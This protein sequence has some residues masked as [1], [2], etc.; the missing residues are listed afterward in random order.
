VSPAD[1]DVIRPAKELK[2][3]E[4]VSLE[5]GEQK[6][7]RFALDK[8]AFAYWAADKSDWRVSEGIYGI[9]IGAS[10]QRYPGDSGNLC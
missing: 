6:T 9:L 1:C 3:F 5:P 2:G 4:K 8:R 7:V 10:K